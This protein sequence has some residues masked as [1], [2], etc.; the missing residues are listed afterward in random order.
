MNKHLWYLM[1]FKNPNSTILLSL[2]AASLQAQ[3]GSEMRTILQE[4]LKKYCK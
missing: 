4:A 3:Q 2:S 1:L